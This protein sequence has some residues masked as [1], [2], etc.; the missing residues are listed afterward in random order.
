MNLDIKDLNLHKK[1]L[2]APL[3]RGLH[4]SWSI[5]S[6]SLS[7]S[8]KFSSADSTSM[9]QTIR[10]KSPQSFLNLS[11]SSSKQYKASLF[12]TPQSQASICLYTQLLSDFSSGSSRNHFEILFQD[13]AYKCCF[14]IVNRFIGI[15]MRTSVK[16]FNFGIFGSLLQDFSSYK[17]KFLAWKHWD[18]YSIGISKELG[19]EFEGNVYL[20]LN[21]KKEIA[22]RIKAIKENVQICLGYNLKLNPNQNL[23]IRLDSEGLVGFELKHKM[24]NWL[25]I[26]ASNELSVKNLALENSAF[27]GF[28]LKLE[29]NPSS[30]NTSTNSSSGSS[31]NSAT[32]L[33]S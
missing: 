5:P 14:E 1:L 22:A 19:G 20:K 30:M 33:L 6:S 17:G 8:G 32:S 16:G 23:R 2:Q 10:F 26:C 9:S 21:D 24:N 29:I 31:T 25:T 27:M 7:L 11:L 15:Y 3:S 28:A 4:L 18:S 12:F 13:Q